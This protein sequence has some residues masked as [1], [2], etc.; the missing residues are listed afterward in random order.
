MIRDII[1]NACIMISFIYILSRL[2]S[3]KSSVTFYTIKEKVVTGISFG[4][5]GFGLM[6]YA[7]QIY[8][9]IRLDL[10]F[11]PILV[12][13]YY[14]G[15]LSAYISAIIIAITRFYFGVNLASVHAISIAIC[16]AIGVHFINKKFNSKP[17][18]AFLIMILYGVFI[19]VFNLYLLVNDIKVVTEA[20]LI[21][22]SISLIAGYAAL[23]ICLDIK[24]SVELFDYY[25]HSSTV[26]H[27]TGL[28]NVRVFDT[29]LNKLIT[30][31]K[32]NQSPFS[33]LLIDIDFFKKVNDTFGHDAGDAVLSQ[34]GKL[35]VSSCRSNDIV[36][37]NGGEEFA[38]ILPNTNL[39][40]A[41]EVAE[42][43]RTTME[44]KYFELPNHIKINVTVSIGVA[45]YP[46][47]TINYETILKQA[48]DSLYDAKNSGRNKVVFQ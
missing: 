12:A 22:G 32:L 37:R 19:T 47:T 13:G 24:K 26:D 38:I 34:V 11:I 39:E 9:N 44:F 10:R 35:L 15:P 28:Y 1:A 21:L 41:V 29:H 3:P 17:Q 43:V 7:F 4:L 42:R 23:Y 30:D 40:K 31:S 2:I 6:F 20:T 48:D 27:L 25:K 18:V 5:L 45:C 36:F 16:T 46:D 33:L 8:G 14:G